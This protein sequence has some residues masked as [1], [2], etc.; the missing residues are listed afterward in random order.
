MTCYCVESRDESLEDVG[1]LVGG[2]EKEHMLLNN[3]TIMYIYGCCLGGAHA[4]P[5]TGEIEE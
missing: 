2:E 5:L 3:R 4:L 1:A